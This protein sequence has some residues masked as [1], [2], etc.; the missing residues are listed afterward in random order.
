MPNEVKTK[1]LALFFGRNELFARLNDIKLNVKNI[2]FLET[3]DKEKALQIINQN[4]PYIILVDIDKKECQPLKFFDQLL[5]YPEERIIIGITEE[6]P[7][8]IVVESIK[9]GLYD[10]INIKTD[11][12]KLERELTK[13][14]AK[15]TEDQ[16]GEDLHQRQREK[17]DF[18]NII[19]KSK[20]IQHIFNLIKKIVG[21]KWVTVLLQGETGTGKELIA[22]AIH[23][24]TFTHFHPFIEINCNTLPENLLESELFGHE[25]GA[26]TDARTLKKGLFEMAQN[27]TLFL[28]EIGDISI[29]IQLKLLKS[30]EEKKIRRLGGIEDITI[31]TRIIAA[32]NKNLQQAVKNSHFRND[33]YYRLNVFSINLPP[34]RNRGDDV[35]ILAHYFLC[36]YAEEYESTLLKF[37]PEAKKLLKEYSWPGNVRELKHAIERVVLLKSGEVI[38]RKDL[39]EAIECETSIGLPKKRISDQIV[40]E[41]PP[42]GLSLCEGEKQL[43]TQM[44]NKTGWNKTRTSQLLQISRPRLDRKIRKYNLVP[45]WVSEDGSGIIFKEANL[46]NQ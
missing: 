20:E 12:F 45:A 5:P 32:T 10:V 13:L 19:G 34:L 36:T 29:P 9:I 25:K 6:S 18:P 42:E 30:I 46:S 14:C 44:L 8:D 40:L 11:I 3:S 31:D 4:Q 1:I 2:K 28:D 23:Y 24:K 41:I 38:D 17:Y 43:I 39:E 26:F 16:K 7:L 37:T 27:G 22:R 21:K 35:I 15:K 33:L